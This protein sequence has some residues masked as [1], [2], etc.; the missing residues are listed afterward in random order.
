MYLKVM[1]QTMKKH[2]RIVLALTFIILI[3][4]GLGQPVLWAQ[5]KPS[6]ETELCAEIL[7]AMKK[8]VNEYDT[9]SSFIL[10][11][12][13]P[14][15]VIKCAVEGDGDLMNIIK[16]AL[17]AGVT[18]AVIT[19]CA[20]LG[21]EEPEKLARAIEELAPPQGQSP[22]QYSDAPVEKPHAPLSPSDF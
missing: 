21:G 17:Y 2:I 1:R 14:C 20:L 16:G 9:V 4:F 13:S 5:E 6:V 11:G 19:R 12:H 10:V 8:G 15:F 18:P 22:G 3:S 7:N